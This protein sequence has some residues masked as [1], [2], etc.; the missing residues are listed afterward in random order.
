MEP[1][2]AHTDSLT[3][4]VTAAAFVIVVALVCFIFIL[5]RRR[6]KDSSYYARLHILLQHS[7]GHQQLEGNITSQEV[8][9]LSQE[10][11]TSVQYENL[12]ADGDPVPGL[13]RG[14]VLYRDYMNTRPARNSWY[15]RLQLIRPLAMEW[16]R[17][18]WGN[19]DN[20][21]R[22]VYDVMQRVRHVPSPYDK[23][24]SITQGDSSGSGMETSGSTYGTME[25][26]AAIILPSG[27]ENASTTE[28]V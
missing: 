1:C 17:N 23:L 4:G 28:N 12:T 16:L 7:R 22:H 5:R 20:F 13:S 3:V 9:S 14:V 24:G 10:T 25:R 21:G 26:P 15:D 8:A 6:K 19:V 27:S 18:A 2:P 11:G